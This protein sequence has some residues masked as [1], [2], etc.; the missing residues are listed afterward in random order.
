M[1]T[2]MTVNILIG[3]LVLVAV[4]TAALILILPMMGDERKLARRVNVVLT[5][6]Q[7][8]ALSTLREA[9]DGGRPNDRDRESLAL[10]AS[11]RPGA[12]ALKL[13]QADVRLSPKGFHLLCGFIALLVFAVAILLLRLSAVAACAV[14][15][16]AGLGMP[17]LYLG[18]RRGK[19]LAQ[20]SD[21]FPEAIDIIVRGVKAG[22]PL[23]DCVKIISTEAREPVRSEFKKVLEDQTIGV[24]IDKAVELLSERVPISETRFFAIVIAIQLRAGGALSEALGNLASVIR[25]RK[26]MQMKI[27]ALSSEAKASAGIIGSMP[28]IV[29]GLVYVVSPAYISLLFTES[30]GLTVMA[31]AGTWMIIGVVVMRNMINFDY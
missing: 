22:L 16:L 1:M 6:A 2:N 3:G 11:A 24:P 5:E 15:I 21:A 8:G 4:V 17:H 31:A 7:G 9:G 26:K 25:D 23:I 14:A 13:Q 18:L 30:L 27:K 10:S 19:K 28:F 12:I 20:F 29:G